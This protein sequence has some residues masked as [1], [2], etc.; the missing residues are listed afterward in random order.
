LR[1]KQATEAMSSSSLSDWDGR[2]VNQMLSQLVL[3]REQLL[4]GRDDIYPVLT[5]TA[6]AIIVSTHFS[7][8]RS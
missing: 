4:H 2:C 7:C 8:K 1:G 5:E 6:A 3:M